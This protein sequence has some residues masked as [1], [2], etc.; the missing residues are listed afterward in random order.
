MKLHIT[1][2]SQG[3]SDD[4]FVYEDDAD[5]GSELS[6]AEIERLVR[7][8]LMAATDSAA[9]TQSVID[10]ITARLKQNSDTLQAAV[11]AVVGTTSGG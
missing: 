5:A 1:V 11:D 6:F 4:V 3:G 8:W 2:G 9:V 7:V 10:E